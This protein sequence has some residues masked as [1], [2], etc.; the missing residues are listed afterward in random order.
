[1]PKL[2][3]P[4]FDIVAIGGSA[5]ALDA[6]RPLLATLPQQFNATLCCAFTDPSRARVP[7]WRSSA[8]PAIFRYCWRSRVTSLDPESVT[9]V[10]PECI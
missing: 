8:E 7:W 3:K 4:R 10:I 6:V 9:S 1:M 2:H 5:G